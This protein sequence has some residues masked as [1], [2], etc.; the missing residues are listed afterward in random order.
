MATRLLAEGHDVVAA[1]EDPHLARLDDRSLLQHAA[2]DERVLI[3]CN[4]RDFPAIV[5]ERGEEMREHA[6]CIIL[7]RV[8]HSEFGIILRSLSRIFENLPTQEAW[9]NLCRF[10]SRSE[11]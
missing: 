6:G 5:R 7:V 1:N 4:V 8:D 3:T 2:S 9:H 11:V 10:V